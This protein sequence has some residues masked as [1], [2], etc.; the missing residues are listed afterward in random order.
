MSCVCQLIAHRQTTL[1]TT[2]GSR[3]SIIRVSLH[4]ALVSVYAAR[5][6]VAERKCADHQHVRRNSL[7][8]ARAAAAGSTCD[9]THTHTCT[10]DTHKLYILDETTLNP[11][12]YK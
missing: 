7:N 3:A 6:N 4:T 5:A 2:L 8:S 10:Y 1:N 9:V 11:L 12:Y